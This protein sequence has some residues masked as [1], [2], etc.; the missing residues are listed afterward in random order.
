MRPL[1]LEEREDLCRRADGVE[2]LSFVDELKYVR[3]KLR[4]THQQILSI[5]LHA[6]KQ[7]DLPEKYLLYVRNKLAERGTELAPSELT[8]TLEKSLCRLRNWLRDNGCIESD[9][10]DSDSRLILLLQNFA[11]TSRP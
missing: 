10:P 5:L 9:I 7:T 8:E 6:P 4:Q 2:L 3:R 1:S 11:R